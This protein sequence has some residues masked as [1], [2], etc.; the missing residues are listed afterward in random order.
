MTKKVHAKKT[1]KK[2]KNKGC[3]DTVDSVS[4]ETFNSSFS[5]TANWRQISQPSSSSESE[6]SDSE[7][8]VNEHIKYVYAYLILTSCH[9][10]SKDLSKANK[11]TLRQDTRECFV[12]QWL[13]HFGPMF[14]FYTPWKCQKTKDFLMFSGGVEMERRAKMG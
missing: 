1:R 6:Y 3:E 8:G 9:T 10:A 12:S 14:H 5:F 11:I 13:T 2:K 4:E 7:N